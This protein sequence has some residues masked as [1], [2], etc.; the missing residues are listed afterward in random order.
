MKTADKSTIKIGARSFLT[1]FLILFALMTVTGILTRIIPSGEYDRVVYESRTII[2]DGS[3]HSIEKQAV[4][5]YR[6]YTSV[7]EVF[8]GE[9]RLTVIVLVLFISFLGAS[10]TILERGN[11]LSTIISLIAGRFAKRKYLLMAAIMLLMMLITSLIGS[12][13]G[14]VPVV[15]IIVP[16]SIALGWDSLVGLGMSLLALAF[17]FSAAITNYFTIGVAQT[18]AELPLFSGTWL[19]IIFFFA[20]YGATFFFVY[21]YAK[22]I[23]KNPE[24]SLCYNEDREVRERYSIENILKDQYMY[25]EASM[26]RAIWWFAGCI[27]T[28][29]AFML[30]AA[31][32]PVIPNNIAFPIVAILFLVG[33][34]GAGRFTGMKG[35]VLAGHFR[36]GILNMLPGIILVLMAMSIPHVMTSGGVMDTI[37]FRASTIVAGTNIY[38][39]VIL[40]YLLTLILN[41][42]ISSASAK[43]FLMMPILI[44]LADMIGLTR[45]TVILAFNFGDGFSNMFYPTSALLLI[46]L[47]FT[48]VGYT[49][50]IRWTM[51]AQLMMFTLSLIFLFF[52]VAIGF[53]PF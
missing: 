41:F 22:K 12:I 39:A 33:G 17:G 24:K 36:S 27:L 19:R 35:K 6:W 1:A 50:W 18:I 44:P 32:V 46:C 10:F 43:A 9:N 23:E 52:A 49:K 30:A 28:G 47:G 45:Q 16:L 15:L 5:V 8:W 7:I 42:F 37:L 20:A 51:K 2:A 14:L 11:V 13:E 25:E 26:R 3:Y 40:V 34:L 4:P 29:F 53:G 31:L 38:T 48:T 21:S